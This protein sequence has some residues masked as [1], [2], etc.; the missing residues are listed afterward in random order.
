VDARSKEG[1][2]FGNIGAVENI[3]S[4]AKRRWQ[5][6]IMKLPDWQQEPD[7]PLE[8]QDFDPDYVAF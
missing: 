5:R 6:R 3:L 2:S 8:A 7:A 1:G 4:A